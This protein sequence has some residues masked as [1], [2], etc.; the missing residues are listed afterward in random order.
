[1]DGTLLDSRVAVSGA[2]VAAVRR[3]GGSPVTPEQVVVSY[4]IGPP[5]ALLPHL[6]GRDLAD[7]ESEAYYDELASATVRPYRGIADVLSALRS[8]GHRLAVFTGASHRAAVMLLTRAGI[9]ADVLV[10]GDEV[11]HPKP[12]GDGLALLPDPA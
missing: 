10:G 2:F 9:F 12:A 3:L 1:M 5:E 7:G 11:L 4:P 8:R 6:L